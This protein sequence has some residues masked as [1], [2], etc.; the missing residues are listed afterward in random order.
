MPDGLSRLV[1][2]RMEPR[3]LGLLGLVAALAVACANDGGLGDAPPATDDPSPTLQG[4]VQARLDSLEAASGLYA[5]HLP[6][7]RELAVRADHPMNAL[8]VIK[9]PVM[10]QA[11]R[12][13]ESGVWISRSAF[14]WTP[15]TCEEA[16]G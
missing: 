11:F 14:R 6:T 4:R 15:P 12:D 2:T 10:V 13:A 3:G 9:I 7:G 1:P 5:K 16:A 8:S